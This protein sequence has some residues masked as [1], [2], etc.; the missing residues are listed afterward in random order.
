MDLDYNTVLSNDAIGLHHDLNMADAIFFN[1][2]TGDRANYVADLGGNMLGI[3]NRFA[4]R[5]LKGN[6]QR[7]STFVDGL[8][9]VQYSVMGS[10]PTDT[11]VFWFAGSSPSVGPANS[12]W[13][14]NS[15]I[16]MNIPLTQAN[17]NIERS[18][19]SGTCLP[20]DPTG[21]QGSVTGLMAFA[22]I[23]DKGFLVVTEAKP[24]DVDVGG[25]VFVPAV[26]VVAIDKVLLRTVLA[27]PSVGT[28]A[29][30]NKMWF[31]DF[32]YWVKTAHSAGNS[33]HQGYNLVSVEPYVGGFE[34]FKRNQIAQNYLNNPGTSSLTF[35]GKVA[36]GATYYGLG[37]NV[38]NNLSTVEA[39]PVVKE[40]FGTASLTICQ[41]GSSGCGAAV[42]GVYGREVL[43]VRLKDISDTGVVR[44]WYGFLFTNTYKNGGTQN[45]TLTFDFSEKGVSH[46][47][48]LDGMEVI[49]TGDYSA[50]MS[51]N[52]WGGWMN[53]NSDRTNPFGLLQEANG[54]FGIVYKPSGGIATFING[55]YGV[56]R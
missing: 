38:S 20:T 55:A 3:D 49:N 2:Y 9:F 23:D 14:G 28:K 47:D 50:S 25:A 51:A 31:S 8:Q 56:R 21:P 19:T 16:R 33:Y 40:F 10:I 1:D 26:G 12:E 44:D 48:W 42:P 36:G 4:Y 46:D 34:Q 27:G 53:N 37:G 13:I 29:K 22:S 52:Y 45:P 39:N 32:G 35:T 30:R 11:N 43:D 24:S 41:A 7:K 18:C 15:E 6:T 17:V 5:D 54:M